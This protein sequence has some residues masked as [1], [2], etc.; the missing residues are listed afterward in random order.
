[1]GEKGGGAPPAEVGPATPQDATAADAWAR[2][3]RSRAVGRTRT[4]QPPRGG[5]Y[6][7]AKRAGLRRFA[8]G[9]GGGERV[10]NRPSPARMRG[11]GSPPR[12]DGC[13]GG[14][15]AGRRTARSSP[16]PGRGVRSTSLGGVLCVAG[17]ARRR[18]QPRPA[19]VT[20]RAGHGG[21]RQGPSA[22]ASRAGASRGG[23]GACPHR[24][25][26]APTGRGRERGERGALRTAVPPDPPP[27]PTPGTPPSRAAPCLL[28][29]ALRARRP[30][31][32]ARPLKAQTR[33]L[34]CAAAAP[35]EVCGGP[36]PG[37][38]PSA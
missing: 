35:G 25:G 37:P 29:G 21:A 30:P 28:P 18:P 23:A 34:Q 11:V 15:R 24:G 13:G 10:P 9:G 20:G 19:A 5:G 38:P 4:R 2:P 7:R 33:P 27:P 8:V 12:A 31:V 22:R 16:C 17:S 1:M 14:G 36:P 6:G 32:P 26:P 3:S